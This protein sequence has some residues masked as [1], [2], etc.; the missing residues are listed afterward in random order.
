M[1]LH[2]V[3]TGDIVNSTK[4]KPKVE[5]K[6]MSSLHRIL[7][8]YP[9]EFYRGDSFQVYL[10]KPEKSL[11]LALICRTM[12]ISLSEGEESN[13]PDTRI[14]IGIGKISAPVKELGEA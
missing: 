7:A 2:A 6:L 9:F 12:A 11:R 14:S 1:D 8:P 13:R 4:L 5:S 3:I 10:E